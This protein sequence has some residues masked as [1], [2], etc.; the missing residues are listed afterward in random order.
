VPARE[1]ERERERGYYLIL[2][3]LKGNLQLFHRVDENLKR[4][5]D[6]GEYDASVIFPLVF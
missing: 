2:L 1:R 5:E 6:I 3:V 4:V